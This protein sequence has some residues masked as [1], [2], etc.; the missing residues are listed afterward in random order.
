MVHVNES[1]RNSKHTIKLMEKVHRKA[2]S[3][4][5]TA[6]KDASMLPVY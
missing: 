3:L 6:I 5:N 2:D 1:E 4:P